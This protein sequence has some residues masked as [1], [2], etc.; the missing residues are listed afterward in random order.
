MPNYFRIPLV[1]PFKFVPATST[2]GI[3]FD[4]KWFYDQIKSFETKRVYHQKWKKT[5]TTKLQIESTLEPENLKVYNCD[6]EIVKEFIWTAVFIDIA[7]RI[8]ETTYDVSDLPNGVYH[9]YQRVAFGSIDWKMISEP[10]SIKEDWPNTLGF[11]Y[12]NSF[13][14]DGV[15]WSTGIQML[16]RCEAGIMDF[17]PDAD[18][19]S[20]VDQT[21]NVDL[22]DGVPFRKFTLYI[23]DEKGVAPYITDIL[24]RIFLQDYILI[25]GK[26][27]T[28]NVGAKWEI[29]KIKNYS[30]VGANLEIVESGNLDSLEFADLTPIGSGIVVAYNIETAVIAPGSLVP[31]ID[32][33]EQS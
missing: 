2:P 18:Q 28:R 16:F 25:E 14:K 29:N 8:W 12:K 1:S 33:E 19:T 4:D 20:Y 22:L 5:E 13:N 30:L 11:L 32:V 10:I 31:I 23:G 15:A 7:Y 21:H 24:N 9:L 3:H 6:Q 17:I 27:Y 26:K